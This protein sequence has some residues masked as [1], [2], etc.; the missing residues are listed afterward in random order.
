[1]PL[2][3]ER[4]KGIGPAKMPIDQTG[5]MGSIFAKTSGDNMCFLLC[6]VSYKRMPQQ[7]R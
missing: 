6:P 5:A 3:S 4:L 7:S 2:R 1:M